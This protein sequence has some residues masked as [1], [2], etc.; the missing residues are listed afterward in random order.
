[1]RDYFSTAPKINKIENLNTQLELFKKDPKEFLSSLATRSAY[2]V[3]EVNRKIWKLLEEINVSAIDENGK[4]RFQKIPT[5]EDLMDL[6]SK[7]LKKEA[8]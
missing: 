7:E 8:A 4:A 1:M 3:N 5:T 2:D 6:L